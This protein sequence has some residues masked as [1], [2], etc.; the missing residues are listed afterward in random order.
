[1]TS[2]VNPTRRVRLVLLGI[3][4]V[5]ALLLPLGLSPYFRQILNI[6]L[7][8]GMAVLGLNFALGYAG[9]LS[10][11]QAAF[12]GIGAYTSALLT[13]SL[14]WPVI[15]G[16]VGAIV[17]AAIAGLLLGMPT[18]RL[19]G[20]YLAMATIGFGII[21]QL[22]L[23]HWRTVTRGTDGVTAIP[24]LSIGPLALAHEEQ[25]YYLLLVVFVVLAWL[26][27]RIRHSRLGRGFVAVRENEL[28]GEA[29]GVDTT[30]YKIFA[31]A[32]TAAYAGAAGSLYAHVSQFISPDSF[33]FEQSVQFLAMLV[34]GGSGSIA[35][36]T[37][38]AGLLTFAPELL[39]FVSF[40]P[41]GAYLAIYGAAIMLT[42]VFLPGGLISLLDR[43]RAK[44]R[45]QATA[46]AATT[47]PWS[48]ESTTAQTSQPLLETRGLVKTFG[49]VVA[50]NRL[51]MTVRPGEIHALIGPNGSGKT[52]TLNVINGMYDATD[53]A[54]ILLGR[55]VTHLKPHSRA[56]FGMSRTF[57]N[58][59][60]FPA[61]SV[62]ENVIIGMHA[63][64]HFS[65]SALLRG[66]SDRSE[67]ASRFEAREILAFVGLA[68]EADTL[69]RNLPYG[70]QRL[71]EIARALASRPRLLLLD[72]PA[73]GLNPRETED[74]VALLRR[75]RA[76]GVTLLLIEHDMNLVMSL[77]DQITVLNFGE[78]ISEGPRA[79]VERDENVIEAYL[80]R[81]DADVD[82]ELAARA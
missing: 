41:A 65:I 39:K 5:A 15:A 67:R 45:A 57:Q 9:Q 74:L 27:H 43:W 32:L 52:T 1:M 12:W 42:M 19:R 72:E 55:D 68:A 71:A 25:R 6:A 22:I 58:I 28:A 31:F 20:H 61:L 33:S 78:K 4:I 64:T 69:A 44:P 77:S 80:G 56:A 29:L 51:D 63:R 76:S 30:R 18:L 10:L 50:V 11:A 70:A 16:F 73:A 36:A 40:L 2:L 75:M 17:V 37:L 81:D 7:I 8:W 21:V 66:T 14:K 3:V 82:L 53:G 35:G 79:V 62:L 60:L 26:A 38:G 54:V 49:G 24:G 59:R 34:I 23:I 46:A 13:V 47:L 48:V